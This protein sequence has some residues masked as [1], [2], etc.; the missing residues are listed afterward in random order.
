MVFV[1]G[2]I[3]FLSDINCDIQKSSASMCIHGEIRIEL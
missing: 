2:T 3:E 1:M